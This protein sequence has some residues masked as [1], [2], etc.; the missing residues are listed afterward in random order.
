[1]AIPSAA[2]SS[3]VPTRSSPI[4]LSLY[5]YAKQ[6]TPLRFMDAIGALNVARRKLGRFF[7]NYDIWLSP[8]TRACPSPGATTIS[9]EQA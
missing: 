4:I 3:P 8:T 2:A 1:M 5:E 7:T 9:A 6:I